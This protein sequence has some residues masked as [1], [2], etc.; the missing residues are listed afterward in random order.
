[1]RFTTDFFNVLNHTNFSNLTSSIATFPV[2]PVAFDAL[3]GTNA[4]TTDTVRR[5]AYL[6]ER[7]ADF[8]SGSNLMGSGCC[9]T[10]F[11]DNERGKQAFPQPPSI[12]W[13]CHGFTL[14]LHCRTCRLRT[15]W[16]PSHTAGPSVIRP[17][18]GVG[19]FSRWQDHCPHTSRAD[20]PASGRWRLAGTTHQYSGRKNPA[21]PGRLTA[22]V[23]PTPARA[24]Y[25][26]SPLRAALRIVLPMLPQ[27]AEIHVRRP[28][29]LPA[30][31]RRPLD[32][33]PEWTPRCQQP[34][35]RQC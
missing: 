19:T 12:T 29:A 14:F 18:R 22:S 21:W 31:L 16:W 30:G 5:E 28:T 8:R 32:P 10:R 23:S 7:A 27:A 13:F 15:G 6:L 25:G 35:R 1:M 17:H 34:S 4:I 26:W 33:L 20:R 11:E 24:V 9:R 2:R 3:A